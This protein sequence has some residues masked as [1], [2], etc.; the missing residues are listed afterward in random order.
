MAVDIEKY[1]EVCSFADDAGVTLVAVSK[2]KS[3]DDIQDLYN[4][5]HRDFGEN[6]VQELTGKTDSLPADIRWHFIG[7][8]QTN[9]VKQIAPFV[10]L[11]QSVDSLKLYTEINKQ[12]EKNNREI[13]ILLQVH[14]SGE[15]SKEGIDPGE[16]PAFVKSLIAQNFKN[17]FVR[18]LMGLASFTGD[19]ATIKSQFQRL[20]ELFLQTKSLLNSPEQFSILS[21][22]MSGDYHLAVS[23]GSTMIRIGNLLFGAR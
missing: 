6:Y 20:R 7:H 22:G 9:K 12:A 10:H 5:G 11:I 4:L 21:M 23:E 14:I 1:Q 18:G 13:G 17:V 19:Q 15:D 3:V 16:L 2:F 8:L